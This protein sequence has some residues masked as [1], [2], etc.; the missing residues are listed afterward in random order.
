PVQKLASARAYQ[1]I[2]AEDLSLVNFKVNIRQLSRDRKILH[3]K[4]RLLGNL[5][6]R[7]RKLVLVVPA[8]DLAHQVLPGDILDQPVLDKLPVAKDRVGIAN[9]ED[10][11]HPVR[12]IDDSLA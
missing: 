1:A 6:F 7:F 9:R 8:D 12:D 5:R 3:P 2:D 10:L 11:G 4:N